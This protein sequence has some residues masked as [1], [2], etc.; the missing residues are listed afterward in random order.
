VKKYNLRRYHLSLSSFAGIV[1]NASHWWCRIRWTDD[2]GHD[3]EAD[4]ERGRGGERTGR[5]DT[6]VAARAAG[7]RLIRK[8]ADGYY[9]VTEGS[10]GVIDPQEVL[11]APGNLKSRLNALWRKFEKLDG[12]EAPKEAWPEVQAI[13]DNWSKLIGEPR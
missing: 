3:Q 4:A 2:E 11:S 6:K 12:W 1:F 7:L 10:S 8:I 5:F 9:V 13:C